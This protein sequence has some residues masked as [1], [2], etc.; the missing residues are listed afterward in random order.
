MG[1][2]PWITY[3]RGVQILAESEWQERTAAHEARVDPPRPR[4]ARRRQT[5]GRTRSRT[6][7]SPT[8][9]SSPPQLRRWHP[10]AGVALAGAPGTA[11]AAGGSTGPT[12][13]VVSV[14]VDALPR[15]R[16]ATRVRLRARPARRDGGRPAQLRLLRAA[17]V[18]DGLPPRPGRACGTRAGRCGSGRAAPTRSSRATGSPARTS[19]RTASSPAAAPLNVLQPTRESQAGARAAGLPARGDGP[20][21]VGVQARA[22]SCRASWSWTASSWPA[23]SARSTC[24]PRPTT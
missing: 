14:D 19:T 24:A 20:L 21:Q 17:R 3:P 11:R 9:P 23:T 5:T 1:L 7:S 4:T 8:T 18:G 13:S 15:R 12:A 2:D 10:G 22:R 6:S 16:A